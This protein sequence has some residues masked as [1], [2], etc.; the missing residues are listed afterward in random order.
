MEK[1]ELRVVLQSPIHR[2]Y[3]FSCV[4]RFSLCFQ[5]GVFP[6]LCLGRW[7]RQTWDLRQVRCERRRCGR[8]GYTF[9]TVEPPVCCV[10][11]QS[12]SLSVLTAGLLLPF[13]PAV[14]PSSPAHALGAQD[15]RLAAGDQLLSVDGRSLVG[16][17]QERYCLFI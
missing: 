15:G 2:L 9:V 5:R 16:L 14:A 8:G 7:S 12:P 17:S 4:L 11:V 10:F 3:S 6:C 13:S 1:H